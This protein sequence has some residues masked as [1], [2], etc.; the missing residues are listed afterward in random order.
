MTRHDTTDT[1]RR[2]KTGRGSIITR[3]NHSATLKHFNVILKLNN[4]LM[5]KFIRF[6]S[7]MPPVFVQLK[8]WH[9]LLAVSY[10]KRTQI[11]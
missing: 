4:T 3:M 6:N 5:L 7:R 11:H 8:N 1:T 2:D 9:L 10:A